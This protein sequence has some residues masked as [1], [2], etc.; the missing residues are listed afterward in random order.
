[1]ECATLVR[2]LADLADPDAV[3]GMARYGIV[4]GTVYGVKIPILRGL[5]R[6]LGRNHPLALELWGTG[7]REGRILAAM[8]AEPEQVDAGLMERWVTA[9]DN[10][11]VC[12]Q[13]CMNLFEKA[14]L[15]WDKAVAWS[16]REE[17]FVKRAG[18]VLMARLAVS[19]KTAADGRFRE[20][21][22][23]I[24]R[25]A[26]D[27]RNYVKKG[28]NWALRQIGK[29]NLTLNGE[30]VIVARKIA[31]SGNAA[32]RWVAADALRELTDERV[33]GRLLKSGTPPRR[34][35]SP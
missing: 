2:R 33:L 3:A 19:D 34:L 25:E 15:A 4:S 29:R 28:I 18:F 30:A 14:S 11:E 24:E 26:K 23:D 1:M 10:W 5:A 27:G 9:F 31:A 13:C 7:S 21:F 32:A 6:E 20:F 22:A 17:E 16:Y 8:T 12:D 35:F